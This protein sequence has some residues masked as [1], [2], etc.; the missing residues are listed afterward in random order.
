MNQIFR[1]MGQ[2]EP[3][4]VK[5]KDGTETSKCIVRLKAIGGKYSDE[6]VAAVLGNGATVEYQQDDLVAA[7]LSFS[8]HENNGA[9]FQDVLVREIVKL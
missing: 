7:D 6:Y 2:T 1:V 9:F 4:S 8:V 5:K 3:V